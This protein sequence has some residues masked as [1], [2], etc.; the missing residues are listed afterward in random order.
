MVFKSKYKMVILNSVAI[1]LQFMS[2]FVFLNQRFKIIILKI[3]LV[4]YMVD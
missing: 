1:K 3:M 4:H 2:N